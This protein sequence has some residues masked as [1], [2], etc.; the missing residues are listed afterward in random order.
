MTGKGDRETVKTQSV[1]CTRLDWEH[2]LRN[3][4]TTNDHNE[5]IT[6]LR[7]GAAKLVRFGTRLSSQSN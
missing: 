5:V 7:S 1:S 4:E 3:R 6:S 2:C